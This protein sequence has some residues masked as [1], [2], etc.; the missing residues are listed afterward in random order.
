MK[1][2]NGEEMYHANTNIKKVEGTKSILDNVDA[3]AIYCQDKRHFT[4]INESI[5]QKDITSVKS[6]HLSEGIQQF[7]SQVFTKEK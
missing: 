3:R 7:L 5:P 2:K 6:V 1:L 4:V